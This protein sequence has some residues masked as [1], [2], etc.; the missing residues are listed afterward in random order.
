MARTTQNKCKD[1]YHGMFNYSH[2]SFILRTQAISERRAWMNFCHQLAKRH[3]VH[4]SHVMRMFNGDHDNFKIK[5][6]VEFTE[7]DDEEPGKDNG[8]D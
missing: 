1:L 8:G 2:Q 5:K 7:V 6:E 4:V 3:D